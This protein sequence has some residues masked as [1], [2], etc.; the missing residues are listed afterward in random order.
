ML[1]DLLGIR[2]I[3]EDIAQCYMVLGIL[4]HNYEYDEDEFDDYIIKPKPSGYRSIHTVIKY[5]GQYIEVQ[6]RTQEMHEVNEFGPASHIAYKILGNKKKF[7]Q[8]FTWTKDLLD[9]QNQEVDGESKYKVR[10]FADS[11]FVFTPKGKVIQL[12]KESTPLDFAFMVHS[13]LGLYYQGAKVN[14]VMRPMNY[15]LDTGDVIEVLKSKRVNVTRDWLKNCQMNA[16]KAK[17]RKHLRAKAKF[18]HN[19]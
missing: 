18:E 1:R 7:N 9:W 13:D 4:H 5:A 8:S 19:N 6:I 2:V 16:T 3:V 10:A 12:Q 17:I 15:R 11:I 14:G